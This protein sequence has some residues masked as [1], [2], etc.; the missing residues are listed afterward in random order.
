[1]FR[2]RNREQ[3]EKV[4]N[5]QLSRLDTMHYLVQWKGLAQIGHS[6]PLLC[7]LPTKFPILSDLP[8]SLIVT[9]P[10]M[11]YTTILTCS[12]V[13]HFMTVMRSFVGLPEA[14]LAR[15]G[16]RVILKRYFTLMLEE[17]V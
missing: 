9:S 7:H 10:R 15:A 5:A 2:T 8:D 3:V 1:M 12:V 11:S 17:S 6:V 16:R 4:K 14:K 13:K